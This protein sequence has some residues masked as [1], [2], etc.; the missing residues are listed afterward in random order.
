MIQL[1]PFTLEYIE[2]GNLPFKHLS[3]SSII[4]ICKNPRSFL[5]KYVRYQFDEDTGPALIGGNSVH[6]GLEVL[7]RTIRDTGEILPLISEIPAEGQEKVPEENK[8]M[9]LDPT[10]ILAVANAH[11][12]RQIAES[13]GRALAKAAKKELESS[14]EYPTFTG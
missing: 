1:A 6:K 14:F 11:T 2:Q 8:L 3:Q 9:V 12:N 13:Q 7:F 10:C 5:T 4:E